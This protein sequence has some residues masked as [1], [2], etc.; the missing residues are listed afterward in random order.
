MHFNSKLILTLL[1]IFAVASKDTTFNGPCNG[2]GGACINTDNTSCGTRTLSGKCPGANNVKCCAA[3]SKP[4]WYINQNQYTK[5]ICKIPGT[6][7]VN[8]SVA[9]SGCGCASL[10]VL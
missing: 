1:L 4:S 5:I 6:D 3:G 10:L 7:P 8:K 9:T 2:G